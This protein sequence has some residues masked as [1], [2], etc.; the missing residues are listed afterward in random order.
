M[1][2]L[3]EKG[4]GNF[5]KVFLQVCFYF[6]IAVLIVLPFVL[7]FAG[8]NLGASLFVIY[9]NGTVLL[10]IAHQF[11]GQFNSLKNCNPFC[12]ENVKRL[13]KAGIASVI[14]AGL[15]LIDLL[16]ELILA[17]N[18]D[19]VIILILVFMIILFIGV[20]IALYILSTLIGQA[21]QYK[22]ENELTI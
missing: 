22:E 6:G 5:L 17:K 21:T 2:I 18:F 12:I 4:I 16:Y 7:Q 11:I 8:L 20:S 1:E 10:Y 9:P 14:E 19:I 13:R 15:W 3:G